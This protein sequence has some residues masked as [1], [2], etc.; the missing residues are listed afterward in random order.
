MTVRQRTDCGQCETTDWT[1]ENKVEKLEEK[2]NKEEESRKERKL[3]Q[4]LL[5]LG[6]STSTERRIN[7]ENDYLLI[8]LLQDVKLL[9]FS[10]L[11]LLRAESTWPSLF[12]SCAV[13]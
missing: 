3:C 11:F 6:Y 5:F 2:Q 4:S 8:K 9:V 7:E 13:N 10:V 12:H 1:R